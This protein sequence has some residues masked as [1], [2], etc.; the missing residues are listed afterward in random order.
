MLSSLTYQ[1]KVLFLQDWAQALSSPFLTRLCCHKKLPV[2][3]L[4]H[5]PLPVV[6]CILPQL[7]S[8]VFRTVHKDPTSSYLTLCSPL[9]CWIRAVRQNTAEVMVFGFWDEV[10]KGIAVSGLASWITCS[11]ESQ[12]PYCEDP[13]AVHGDALV[14][15]NQLPR[16]VNEH[17]RN[18]SS[19]PTQA[20][21]LL[22]FWQIFWVRGRSW[23]EPT[24]LILNS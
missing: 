14:E 20:F 23:A 12:I 7:S 6:I 21:R 1:A 5:N 24:K 9:P 2:V 22:Q 10:A 11:G 3:Y 18:A 8:S 16:H 13:Q 15:K 17:L 4:P 19:H